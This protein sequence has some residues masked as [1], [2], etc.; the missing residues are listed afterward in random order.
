MTDRGVHESRLVEVDFYAGAY[1]QSI[2][3]VLTT[4]RSIA[5]LRAVFESLADAPI[6]TVV[7]LVGLPQVR[8]SGN[9]ERPH[10]VQGRVQG[11]TASCP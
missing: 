4:E 8:T 2:L 5:W 3:L 6:G 9:V 1:G 7:S 11:P 10:V